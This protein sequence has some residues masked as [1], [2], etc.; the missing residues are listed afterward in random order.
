MN[1]ASSVLSYQ[2]IGGW[3]FCFLDAIAELALC[4]CRHLQDHLTH[5]CDQRHHFVHHTVC[6]TPVTRLSL[7][8]LQSVLHLWSETPSCTSHSLPNTC[9]KTQQYV[10]L[11]YNLSY[12]CD[13]RHAILYPINA[14]NLVRFK[15]RYN[16]QSISKVNCFMHLSRH[17]ALALRVT[18]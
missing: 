11:C 7:S 14:H 15:R 8:V 10:I 6:P 18:S 12:I 17:A 13:H 3:P 9:D 16:Y 5:T 2:G 4:C 1:E